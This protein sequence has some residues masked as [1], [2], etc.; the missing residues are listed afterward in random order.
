MKS[1]NKSDNNSTPSPLISEAEID[2]ISSV[3]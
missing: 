1:G 2:T 3:N